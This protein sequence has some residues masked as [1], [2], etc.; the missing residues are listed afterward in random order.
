VN[1]RE[2]IVRSLFGLGGGAAGAAGLRA[3]KPLAPAP[4]PKPSPVPL[5]RA[6][7]AVSLS[8]LQRECLSVSQ[9][10][11]PGNLATLG[12]LTALDGVI[13]ST[14]AEVILTGVRAEEHPALHIDDLMV[15]VRSAFAA[16][17]EYQD[18]PGC[19]IDPRIREGA[20]ER[21]WELQQVRVLGMPSDCRMAARHVAVDYQLKFAGADLLKLSDGVTGSFLASQASHSPCAAGA[22]AHHSSQH[23]FWFCAR[24][25][26]GPRYT[27]HEGG[28]SSTVWID[29]PIE[30]QVLRERELYQGATRT[31][32]EPPDPPAEEFARQVSRLLAAGARR[33]YIEVR[34]D[35]RL[36]EAGRLM[37]LLK[38]GPDSLEYL[39]HT[40]G[41]QRVSVPELVIGVRRYAQ[42][43]ILCGGEVEN[44]GRVMR[45]RQHRTRLSSD[46]R[47][48][49]EAAVRVTERD[50]RRASGVDSDTERVLHARPS[51]Q[52]WCWEVPA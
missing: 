7:F 11:L 47:G 12:G 30:V 24:Y 31:G 26:D 32:T 36:I 42:Q 39:L 4:Q 41:H 43:E 27:L 21:D 48:G 22:S 28:R 9:P 17:P 10:P 5:K 38:V 20:P 29:N 46:Y 1:R 52:V 37:K 3:R 23:R 50:F 51:R 6:R 35:F 25:P 34:S 18:A 40:H 16:G 15:A 45:T 49:V 19:T 8:G 14:H 33:D 13:V 44:D 2:W